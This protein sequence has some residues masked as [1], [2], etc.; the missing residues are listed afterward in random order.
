M[1]YRSIMSEKKTRL[2]RYI[3]HRLSAKIRIV[4]DDNPDLDHKAVLG[5]A[6]GILRDEE[7]RLSMKKDIR[8]RERGN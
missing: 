2:S 3:R 6:I 4:R 1:C 5:K 8:R 7:G